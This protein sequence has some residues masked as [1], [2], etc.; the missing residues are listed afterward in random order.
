MSIS[1]N[2]I[3]SLI[4]IAEQGLF[5]SCWIQPRASRTTVVGLYNDA[6]KIALAAP[7]VDGKANSELC[8]FFAKSLGLP[9]S[10]VEVV[11]GQTSRKKTLLLRG[12]KPETLINFLCQ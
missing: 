1:E 8:A 11:S 4:R 12:L 5:L 2:E 10:A 9:K 6:L 3:K 7:P